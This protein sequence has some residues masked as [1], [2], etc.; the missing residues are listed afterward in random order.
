MFAFD[1]W[2]ATPVGCGEHDSGVSLGSSLLS[3][4]ILA[5]VVL[6]KLI[7]A[8]KFEGFGEEQDVM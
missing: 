4:S 2:Y 1:R 5:L 7:K 3:L 8:V 6:V